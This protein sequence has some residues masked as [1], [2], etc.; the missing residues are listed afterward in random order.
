MVTEG[1][2]KEKNLKLCTGQR[3]FKPS[4]SLQTFVS[5]YKK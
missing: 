5:N 4:F 1:G 2:S 3:F